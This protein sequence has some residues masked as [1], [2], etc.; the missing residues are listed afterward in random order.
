MRD[1]IKKWVQRGGAL[2]LNGGKKETWEWFGLGWHYEG[3]YYRRTIHTYN[4]QFEA[5][6][7]AGKELFNFL[8]TNDYNVKATMLNGVDAAHK[9]YHPK[10]GATTISPVGNIPGFGGTPIDS[11]KCRIVIAPYGRGRVAFVGDVDAEASTMT[12]NCNI[13]DSF[14]RRL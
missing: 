4:S 1:F 7:N 3:D 2:V 8:G 13:G 11:E 6:P 12:W 10:A 14:C 5:I 9:V